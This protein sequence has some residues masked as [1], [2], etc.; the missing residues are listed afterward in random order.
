MTARVNHAMVR[1]LVAVSAQ[2]G[3]E[4]WVTLK[5]TKGFVVGQKID[6]D[7]ETGLTATTVDGKTHPLKGTYLVAESDDAAQRLR[8]M[9]AVDR[10]PIASTGTFDGSKAT[11]TTYRLVGPEYFNFFAM[12][13]AGVG[14]LFILVAMLYKEQSH[15]RDGR[16]R[17]GASPADAAL[18]E[19]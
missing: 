12:V 10:K 6:F 3:S 8:L 7:G 9:D 2:T 17:A 14:V 11:V 18:L 15:V 16:R 4:T 1:P 5:D 19:S 13:M